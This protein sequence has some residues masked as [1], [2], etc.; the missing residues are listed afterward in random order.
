MIC[1]NY[2][3]LDEA[4]RIRHR[5]SPDMSRLTEADEDRLTSSALPAG[6]R[7]YESAMEQTGV[8]VQISVNDGFL[9]VSNDER[10]VAIGR[11]M[12]A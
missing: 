9:A 8:Q 4:S 7:W 11:Q 12:I 10:A 2:P 3:D 6:R 5:L 1:C